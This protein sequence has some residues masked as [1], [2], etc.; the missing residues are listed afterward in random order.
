MKK[1]IGLG[2]LFDRLHCSSHYF[3]FHFHDSSDAEC[4]SYVTVSAWCLL[5]AGNIYRL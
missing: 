4:V 5:T 1:N 2:R 3:I